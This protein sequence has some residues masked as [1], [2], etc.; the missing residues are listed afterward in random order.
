MELESG[1][2]LLF[3]PSLSLL[4]FTSCCVSKWTN[5][6]F[7]HSGIVLKNPTFTIEPLQGLYVLESTGLD[8]IPD[9]EDNTIKFGVQIR[10]L[11]EV[12]KDYNGQIWVRKLRC[13]RDEKFEKSLAA[14]HSAIYNKPYDYGFDYIKAALKLQIGNLQ[15][16][17]KFFCSAL[18]AFVYV[19]IGT[20]PID[21]DWSI[22]TPKDLGSEP[23]EER[24]LV[25]IWLNPIDKEII[26]KNYS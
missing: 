13:K 24:D 4:E 8:T 14:V 10:K 9:S 25:L 18:C 15:K 21:T 11:E 12:I 23:K 3:E 22:V 16:T 7:G 26:L 2:L 1:D 17:N 20:L 6:K 5:S 19:G